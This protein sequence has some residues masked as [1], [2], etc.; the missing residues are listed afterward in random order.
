MKFTRL[1]LLVVLTVSTSLRADEPAGKFVNLGPQIRTTAI[2]GSAF[3][4]DPS[5]LEIIYT[6]VRGQPGHLAGYDIASGKLL[7]DA[8]LSHSDGAWNATVSTDGWLYLPGG[9]GRLLRYKPGTT[10]VEDLGP[11]LPGETVIWDVTA[12]A[13]GEVFGATYPGCRVFRYRAGE[14]FSD[15]CRGPLVKDEN[16]V[17]TVAYDASTAKLYAGVGSHAHLIEIDTKTGEKAE[18]LADEV[19]GQEAVYTLKVIPN[20]RSGNRLL[21]WVTNINH[22]LIYNLK[23]HQIERNL[24]DMNVKSVLQSPDGQK[25]SYSDGTQLLSIDLDHPDESPKPIARCIGANA[26]RDRF[27]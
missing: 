4:S 24:G 10:E 19:Q 20:E 26:S 12:G 11:A 27:R 21:I 13:A 17:R 22:T 8:P 16:Y 2:Q 23:T 1:L 15:V 25:L 18:L 6:A 5:G 3:I 14:G 9:N 7:L